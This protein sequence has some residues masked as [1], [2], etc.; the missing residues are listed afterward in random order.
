MRI[1]IV[2]YNAGNTRSVLCALSRLGYEATVT[3]EHEEL[4]RA[5]R[6]IFPGVGEASTA[7]AYLRNCGLD[8]LLPTLKQPFL[9]IC[10]GMQLMCSYSEEHET[11]GLGIFP[12]EVRKFKASNNEKIPHMGWNTID[13]GDSPLFNGLQDPLWC[14]FVHSYYVPL[15]THTIA[16]SEYASVRFTASL[17]KDNFWGCQFH[18][19]KSGSAGEQMLK[20]FLEE[21]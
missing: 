4:R 5:D 7:M 19:E 2:R 8:S 20:N 15:C 3:G 14:Y 1:A 11:R 10:L 21:V 18:P 16:A 9:G 13:A 17:R 6:I 12:Q